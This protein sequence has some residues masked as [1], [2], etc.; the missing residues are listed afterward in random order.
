MSKEMHQQS[1][2][3]LQRDEAIFKE[4]VLKIN[5]NVDAVIENARQKRALF[6]QEEADFRIMHV[7][8]NLHRLTKSRVKQRRNDSSVWLIERSP[9]KM[10]KNSWGKMS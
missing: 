10:H 3:N 1:N 7:L 8:L 6:A 4:Q 9:W 5:R 2:D